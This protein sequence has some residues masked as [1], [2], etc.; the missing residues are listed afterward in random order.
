MLQKLFAIACIY[1]ATTF[2]VPAY[3]NDFEQKKTELEKIQESL[4]RTENARSL[5][6]TKLRH[7]S[8]D[9]IA[10]EKDM[11]QKAAEIQKIETDLYAQEKRLKEL[12]FEEQNKTR[13]LDLQRSNAS[14]LVSAAWSLQHRPQIAAWLLPEQNRERALTV[15]A[16]HMSTL[17]VKHDIDEISQSMREL[18]E[19]RFS[20]LQTQKDRMQLKQ[21]LNNEKAALSRQ[22]DEQQQLQATLQQDDGIYAKKLDSLIA[23]ASNLQSLVSSLEAEKQQKEQAFKSIKPINKPNINPQP[24]LPPTPTQQNVQQSAKAANFAMARG[25][26]RLP[27]QGRIIGRFGERRGANDRLKGLQ[28]QTASNATITNPFEGEV[29]F[30]GE[31]LDYGNMVIIR[32]SK[33]Y[34]TLIAGLSRLNVRR[35]QFL[36]EGAPIGAMDSNSKL[37]LELRNQ[38]QA[39]DPAPWYALNSN[40]YAKR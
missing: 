6:Q 23:K 27:A 3:A 20:M 1:F 4:Q 29:L 33:Q 11:V 24:T 17:S 16:L 9:M 34:H 32:H 36:L 13:Q 2:V 18:N 35:G 8:R 10:L 37:Y 7:L 22:L 38:S 19:I 30:V 21:N 26:L 39:I 28:I 40:N 15:R 14:R 12:S 31:F 5:T 25:K